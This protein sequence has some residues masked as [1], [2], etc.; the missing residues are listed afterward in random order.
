MVKKTATRSINLL[1][2]LLCLTVLVFP[3]SPATAANSPA[4]AFPLQAGLLSAAFPIRAGQPSALTSGI[5][6]IPRTTAVVVVDGVCSANEYGQGLTETFTDGNGKPATVY[7]VATSDQLFVCLQAQIGSFPQRFARVYLDPQGDGS[8]YVYA[9]QGDDAFQVNIDSTISRT[10]YKG[11]GSPVPA[12]WNLTPSLDGAWSGASTLSAATGYESYEYGLKLSTLGFGTNCNIFGLSVFHH[13]FASVGDDYSWPAGSIYDQ[14]RTWQLARIQ[15]T[16]CGSGDIAYVYRGNTLDSTSFFN[17]LTGAGYNVDLIP[18]SLVAT[19]DFSIYKLII[20]AD[21]TG[22]L[23]EW[24]IPPQTAVQV[25]QIKAANRPILGLGEGGYSFFG[26]LSLFIG[27]PRGWHGPQNVIIKATAP[28]SGLFDPPSSPVTHYTTPFNNVGIYL[29]PNQVLPLDVV[30]SGLESPLDDHSSL[31]SQDCRML[32][33]NSG[34]PLIMTSDGKLLFL[35]TVAAARAFQCSTPRPPD[36]V[37]ISITKTTNLPVGA[38]VVPGQVITYTITYTYSD[39]LSCGNQGDAKIIDY[40]P[41]DTNYVPNSASGGISPAGDGSLTW[42]ISPAAGSNSQTFK[43]VVA[44]TQC[45]NQRAVNNQATLLAMGYAPLTSSVSNQVDCPSLAFPSQSP[46]YAEDELQV[47]PYPLVGG[48]PSQVSLRLTN[49]ATAPVAASVEFQ[50]SPLGLG[51]GLS[52][53]TFDSQ[54]VSIPGSSTIILIASYLPSENGLACFQARVTAPG[55]AQPL[56]TQSCLDNIEDFSTGAANDLTFSV[57]NP[58]GTAADIALVVVNTCPG[59]SA[60]I[61]NPSTGV[62]TMVGANDTEIRSATLRVTPPSPATLG[63]GCHIDVQA[64]IDS[65]LIGGIRKLDVP[66]VHLPTHIR[67]PWEEPEIVFVPDPPKAGVPG[68]LCIALNNPLGV[69]KIVSVEFDVADFGAGIGFTPI[70]TQS[71]TLPPHSFNSYCIPWTPATSGTL[72]RCILVRLNQA[73]YREMTSQRNVD[74]VRTTGA[75]GSLDIPFI[76]GNPDLVDHHL[77]FNI[78]TSGLNAYWMPEFGPN[79]GDPPPDILLA[80]QTLTL[81]L[82]FVPTMTGAAPAAP[83]VDFRF[84]DLTQVSVGMLLDGQPTSGF[85]VVLEMSNIFL[86]LIRR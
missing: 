17:L 1:I 74:I 8:G 67:P 57:G 63:S 3:V 2:S 58:T 12:S 42:S 9:N 21:D 5:L 26:Q 66:P 22:S 64:W 50:V 77:T 59:W 86:P 84:G 35:H 25:A 45:A 48:S 38:H 73:G 47:T 52:Y 41:A 29:P 40:I 55:M 43:V 56:V 6:T 53:T 10:S 4:A 76:V 80:G 13:W 82:H 39:T 65:Q 34:N 72:H 31:I 69:S 24:G 16:N 7:L 33:G 44:D 68:Q 54:I 14:P 19:T 49:S 71:F 37:C 61:T 79:P 36:S 23:N 85:T 27:W 75:L 20:I 78:Q 32:W 15:A 18:L 51:A 83:P 62:L 11:N 28:L 60:V 81:H 46:L 30:P 70:A